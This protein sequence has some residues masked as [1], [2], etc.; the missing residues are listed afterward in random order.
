MR[1]GETSQQSNREYD[2]VLFAVSKCVLWT[3]HGAVQ[4][5]W[6]SQE[7]PLRRHRDDGTID[8]YDYLDW[9]PSRLI[10]QEPPGFWE[11]AP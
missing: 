2:N 5:S 6:I 1:L 8:F 9:Q 10:W 4:Q 3:R 11:N 7:V